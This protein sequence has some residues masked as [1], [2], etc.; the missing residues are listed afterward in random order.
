MRVNCV[1]NS[2][3]SSLKAIELVLLKRI[4]LLGEKKYFLNRFR[5]SLLSLPHNLKV[6]FSS[7]AVN[8]YCVLK[9]VARSIYKALIITKDTSFIKFL[10]YLFMLIT[11]VICVLISVNSSSIDDFALKTFEHDVFQ[12]QLSVSK[13]VDLYNNDAWR[14][15]SELYFFSQG[16]YAYS[17]TNAHFSSHAPSFGYYEYSIITADLTSCAASLNTFENDV[18]QSQL[19]VAKP[20]DLYNNDAWRNKSE[21]YFYSQGSYA[22]SMT[23]AHLSSHAPSL[24]C[25]F[26]IVNSFSSSNT[27]ASYYDHQNYRVDEEKNSHE[28]EEFNSKWWLIPCITIRP[29]FP[30]RILSSWLFFF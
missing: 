24:G 19:S 2:S 17:M 15:K 3:S 28:N 9:V 10:F 1:D 8:L 26:S 6:L 29:R 14:N 16:S 12:S 25:F 20:V 18:F 13:P 7:A 22:Y 21:L 4:Q 23:N 30:P 5:K 11:S 27:Q